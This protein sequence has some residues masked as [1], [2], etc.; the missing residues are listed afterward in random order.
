[1]M[2]LP[3]RLSIS[4]SPPAAE[5]CS[6]MLSLRRAR[7]QA[8]ASGEEQGG[9]CGHILSAGSVRGSDGG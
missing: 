8:V 1:M 7:A 3:Q 2:C 6:K 4:A 5:V 9:F